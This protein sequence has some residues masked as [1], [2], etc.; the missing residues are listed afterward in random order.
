MSLVNYQQTA[1]IIHCDATAENLPRSSVLLAQGQ[2]KHFIRVDKAD[3]PFR[4]CDGKESRYSLVYAEL[5]ETCESPDDE[6]WCCVRYSER[7]WWTPSELAEIGI[8]V[9]RTK[10]GIHPEDYNIFNHVN[11]F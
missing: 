2:G 8:N 7:Q 4:R 6:A 1:P 11:L 5:S 3:E 9:R 10:Q